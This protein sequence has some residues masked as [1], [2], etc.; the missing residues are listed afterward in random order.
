MVAAH[1]GDLKAAKSNGMK[2]IYV[3]RPKEEDWD[4]E[5]KEY[6]N[7]KEWVDMWVTHEEGG[8]LEVA[9]RFGIQ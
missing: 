9:R 4:P 1:L 7:A 5:S 8:F 3:E 2:A 6:R